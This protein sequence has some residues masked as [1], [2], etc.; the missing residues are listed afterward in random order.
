MIQQETDR[1]AV[2]FNDVVTARIWDWLYI[3]FLEHQALGQ[4]RKKRSQRP[5][6]SFLGYAHVA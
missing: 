5:E 1:H 6:D 3:A 2:T 4:H